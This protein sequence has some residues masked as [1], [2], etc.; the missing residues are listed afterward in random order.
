MRGEDGQENPAWQ[1]SPDE[2]DPHHVRL[3][4]KGH[5][6]GVEVPVAGQE[7]VPQA[8]RA[9]LLPQDLHAGLGVPML[10]TRP[11]RT[12]LGLDL[13]PGEGPQ[14]PHVKGATGQITKEALPSAVE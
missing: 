14:R 5:R 2:H 12:H 6:L 13:D 7:Q 11:A 9:A 10:R 4:P 1:Q 8:L 3:R